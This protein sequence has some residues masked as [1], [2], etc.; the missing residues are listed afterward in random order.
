M[1]VT[2]G[3][4]GGRHFIECGRVCDPDFPLSWEGVGVKADYRS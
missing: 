2:S 4:C 1:H 3:L